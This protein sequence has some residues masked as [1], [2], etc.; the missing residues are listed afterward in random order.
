MATAPQK[1]AVNSDYVGKARKDEGQLEKERGREKKKKSSSGI[2]LLWELGQ[3]YPFELQFI[4][5]DMRQQYGS[6]G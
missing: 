4:L 3:K 6:D 1:V 2:R 5:L